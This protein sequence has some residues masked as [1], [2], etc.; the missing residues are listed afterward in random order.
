MKTPRDVA[1]E[2]GRAAAIFGISLSAERL[3]LYLET[4]TPMLSPDSLCAAIRNACV[5]CRFFPTPSE[6]I[7]AAGRSDD[8]LAAEAW[9]LA[10]DI[11][12]RGRFADR[13]AAVTPEIARAVHLIGG[14]DAL[15]LTELDKLHFLERRFLEVYKPIMPADDF[16]R[17]PTAIEPRRLAK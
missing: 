11:A 6:I 2:L 5:Q 14:W 17:V 9:R 13:N 4:L 15:G 16:V 7:S 3:A 12:G 8:Q 1:N 10:V